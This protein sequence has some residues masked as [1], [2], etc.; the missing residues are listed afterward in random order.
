MAI[1]VQNFN[2]REV[3]IGAATSTSSLATF[4]T[5]EGVDALDCRV[6]NIGTVG[7]W[8]LAVPPAGTVKN[9]AG[10]V[11]GTKASYILPGEDIVI[12]KGKNA[13]IALITDTG[14]AQVILHAGTGS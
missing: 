3:Q 4:T 7:V 6:V 2:C 13:N 10:G 1:F 11:A 5:I 8:V 12:G 9:I 14:T